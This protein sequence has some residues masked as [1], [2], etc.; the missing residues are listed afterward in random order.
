M[1]VFCYIFTRGASVGGGTT[2]DY[3]MDFSLKKEDNLISASGDAHAYILFIIKNSRANNIDTEKNKT[4]A[5]MPRNIN[6]I[7]HA[8]TLLKKA[9]QK[10]N[11]TTPRLS[12]QGETTACA[13]MMTSS[14]QGRS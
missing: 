7:R 11:Y 6:S 12:F 10:K 3:E 2:E 9:K 5:S 1:V 4:W 13:L 8:L 14:T